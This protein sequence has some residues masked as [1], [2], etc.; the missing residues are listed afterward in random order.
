M[1]TVHLKIHELHILEQCMQGVEVSLATWL[2]FVAVEHCLS[3]LSRVKCSPGNNLEYGKAFCAIDG[4]FPRC[5]A[6][7]PKT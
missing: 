1:H 4:R 6:H 7:V 5:K 3:S 2:R